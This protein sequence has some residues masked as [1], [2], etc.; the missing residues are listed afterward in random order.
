MILNTYL[1]FLLFSGV[2][3]AGGSERGCSCPKPSKGPCLCIGKNLLKLSHLK[4]KAN[5]ERHTALDKMWLVPAES[6]PEVWKWLV[7][8]GWVIS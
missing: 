6:S 3:V 7:F 4:V 2:T 8:M 1:K 5:I